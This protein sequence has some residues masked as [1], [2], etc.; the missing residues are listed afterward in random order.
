MTREQK[1]AALNELR[2]AIFQH[3]LWYES[4]NRTIICNQ[5]P[6]ERDLAEDAHK[7]WPF[8]K[9]LHGNGAAH[10]GFRTN[11]S[12]IA[13]ANELMHRYAGMM[14]RAASV[15][16]SISLDDYELFL[17]VLK[18]TRAQLV[19][20]KHQLENSLRESDP[21]TGAGNY[22]HMLAWLHERRGL[23]P[24]HTCL[25]MMD[26]DHFKIVNDTYGHDLGDEFLVQFVEYVMSHLRPSDDFFR[27]GGE[28]FLY[29]AADSDVGQGRV[30]A[31]QLRESLTKKEF[32]LEGYLP[33]TMT[34]SFG[35]SLLHP[36]VPVEE[37]IE[38][39]DK[40]LSAA[41]VAGRDRIA[42]WSA[43]MG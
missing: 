30:I 32:K 39:A 1:R 13:A 26:V 24:Q 33:L 38:R 25:V 43:S 16:S 15:R 14:L 4:F 34:A 3:D 21:L 10:L 7:R 5:V 12:Q 11:L 29:G 2:Q 20:I 19:S 37:S 27:L 36:D 31:E 17:A 8:G 28:K 42:L 22:H 18:Q 41:K 23:E 40:A 9:W 35:L 6:D